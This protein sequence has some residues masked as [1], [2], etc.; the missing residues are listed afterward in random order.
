[1][2]APNISIYL[3]EDGKWVA[4]AELGALLQ[5]EHEEFLH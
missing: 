5:D 1:M 2:N 4:C 3:L